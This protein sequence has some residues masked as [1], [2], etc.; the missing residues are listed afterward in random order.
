M[1][2]THLDLTW[3]GHDDSWSLE[4]S[5]S[6]TTEIVRELGTP[7]SAQR[8]PHCRSIVYSRRHRLCSVCTE[9]LPEKVLFS[10]KEAERV[11]QLLRVER[12]KHRKWMEQRDGRGL[13]F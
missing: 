11:E 5:S 9:P 6:A 3:T 1:S 13:D 7:R 2:A 8:C 4:V 12:Q 10:I